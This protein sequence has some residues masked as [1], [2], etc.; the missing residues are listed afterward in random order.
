M[1]AS[2]FQQ[3]KEG[4]EKE[5]RAL[6]AEAKQDNLKRLH[7]DQYKQE[8]DELR[9]ERTL[10]RSQSRERQSALSPAMEELKNWLLSIGRAFEKF[11]EIL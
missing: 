3:E 2:N 7:P 5:M 6:N 4:L 11:C 9:R 1:L 10:D 8:M